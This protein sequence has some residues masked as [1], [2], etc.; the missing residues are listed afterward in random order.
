YE[1]QHLLAE[2]EEEYE[3][4]MDGLVLEE[5]K[6]REQQ[7]NMVP[8][9]A[10]VPLGVIPKGMQ[11]LPEPEVAAKPTPLYLHVDLM[12]VRS[13][14]MGEWF[15]DSL[16]TLRSDRNDLLHVRDQESCD[17]MKGTAVASLVN[18]DF[19]YFRRVRPHMPSTTSAFITTWRDHM[20]RSVLAVTWSEEVAAHAHEQHKK[21][22]RK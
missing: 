2:H 17:I 15:T 20:L 5:R 16:S 1:V 12:R 4:I 8:L 14:A 9:S 6:A 7:L 13:Q 3:R 22:H 11:L 10:L 18:W 21:Q 19:P